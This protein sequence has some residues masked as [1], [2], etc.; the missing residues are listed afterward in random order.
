[1]KGPQCQKGVSHVVMGLVSGVP[2][3]K[4][5]DLNLPERDEAVAE[6]GSSLLAFLATRLQSSLGLDLILAQFVLAVEEPHQQMQ[7]IVHIDR[8]ILEEPVEVA[9]ELLAR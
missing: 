9:S 6:I 3:S 4:W 2:Q 1:M 8:L 5:G 7:D